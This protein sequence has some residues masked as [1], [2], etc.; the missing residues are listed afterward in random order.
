MKLDLR[1]IEV[2]DRRMADVLKAKTPAERLHIGFNIWISTH[3]MLLSHI[4]HIHPDWSRQEVERE[5]ARRLL[6]GSV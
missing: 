2:V 4:G 6:H 5:V 1:Q 3:R